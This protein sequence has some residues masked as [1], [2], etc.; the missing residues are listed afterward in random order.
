MRKQIL[1]IAM[2]LVV[3]FIPN[4][5][6]FGLWFLTVGFLPVVLRSL[7][8]ILAWVVAFGMSTLLFWRLVLLAAPESAAAAAEVT[9]AVPQASP[10]PKVTA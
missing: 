6:G 4:F 10:E 7:A 5:V 3:F 8:S 9:T 1:V 2:S